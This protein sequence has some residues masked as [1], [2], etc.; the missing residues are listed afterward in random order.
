M[1]AEIV[2]FDLLVVK[3]R[4]EA[5]ELKEL[6]KEEVA[7]DEEVDGRLTNEAMSTACLHVFA[8]ML[9]PAVALVLEYW[10]FVSEQVTLSYAQLGKVGLAAWML[11]KSGMGIAV[12]QLIACAIAAPTIVLQLLFGHWAVGGALMATAMFA[13]LHPAQVLSRSTSLVSLDGGRRR[14]LH[15]RH[16]IL[17]FLARRLQAYEPSLL[18]AQ[19]CSIL[20]C[21]L[22]RFWCGHL[23][24]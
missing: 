6:L 12:G 24:L 21:C 5:H 2:E 18:Q 22:H 13:R 11:G 10:D 15:Y 17:C 23:V 4:R 19:S 14:C 7:H 16:A 9:G 1:T 20:R 8:M 3:Q